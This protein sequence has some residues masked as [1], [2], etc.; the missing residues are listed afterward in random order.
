MAV[1][2]DAVIVGQ[3]SPACQQKPKVGLVDHSSTTLQ[4]RHGVI[5]ALQQHSKQANGRY[6]QTSFA[7]TLVSQSSIEAAHRRFLRRN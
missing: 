2:T 3:M 4:I 6:R 7:T 1:I 5:T